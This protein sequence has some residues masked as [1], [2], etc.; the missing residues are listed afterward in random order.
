MVPSDADY[1]AAGL[2]RPGAL[3]VFDFARALMVVDRR[4]EEPVSLALRR[5]MFGAFKEGDRNFPVQAYGLH[6]V[7]FFGKNRPPSPEGMREAVRASQRGAG[8]RRPELARAGGLAAP[9][10]E[11]RSLEAVEALLDAIERVMKTGGR[12]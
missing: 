9:R 2:V 11:D 3:R 10:G 7:A 12:L 5:R 1:Q 6:G 4:R 8:P